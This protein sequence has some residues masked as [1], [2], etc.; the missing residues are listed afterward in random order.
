MYSNQIKIID[1]IINLPKC[2]FAQI[3]MQQKRQQAQGIPNKIWTQPQQYNHF[4]NDRQTPPN[5]IVQEITNL[6]T[7]INDSLSDEQN[8]EFY[9]ETF[10]HVILNSIEENTIENSSESFTSYLNRL[11]R[12]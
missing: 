4:Q 10:N 8:I 6:D 12:M 5:Y 2:L 1:L 7:E 9:E 3:I 11:S